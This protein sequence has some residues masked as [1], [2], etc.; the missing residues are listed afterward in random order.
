MYSED[1]FLAN[2]RHE[3][4]RSRVRCAKWMR[5]QFRVNTRARDNVVQAKGCCEK[6]RFELEAPRHHAAHHHS[7]AEDR[8]RIKLL[9]A[10]QVAIVAETSE[11]KG[12]II[13]DHEERLAASEAGAKIE[14]RRND[15]DSTGKAMRLDLKEWWS[16]QPCS[17]PRRHK[18]GLP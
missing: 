6:Y 15:G 13:L 14:S 17:D 10:E 4:Q 9:E 3:Q 1:G 5:Q 2:L 18:R 8:R 12:R 7:L 16:P 11:I